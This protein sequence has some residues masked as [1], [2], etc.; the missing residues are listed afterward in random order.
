MEYTFINL[1]VKEN[2][3]TGDSD[4]G[5]CTEVPLTGATGQNP[6]E[7]GAGETP[8]NGVQLSSSCSYRPEKLEGLTEKVDN[9]CHRFSRKNRSGAAKK[10]AREARLTKV[11]TGDSGSGQSMTVPDGQPQTPQKP[12][13]SEPKIGEDFVWQI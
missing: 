9:L 11:P 7:K 10:R 5:S 13:I 6:V 3:E 1:E 8:L 12:E 4:K 2:C